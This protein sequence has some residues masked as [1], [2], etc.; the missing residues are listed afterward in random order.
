[1]AEAEF[2]AHRIGRFES[3]AR[4]IAGEKIRV[5]PHPRDGI[6]AVKFEHAQRPARADAVA[7]EKD[8]DIPHHAL[9][10]PRRFDLLAPSV[11]DAVDFLQA[12]G[13]CFDDVENFLAEFRDHFFGVNRTDSLDQSAAEV[14]LDPLEGGGRLTADVRR[15]QLHSVVTIAFPAPLGRD[16]F[17]G[18]DGRHRADHRHQ[19]APAF[20]FHLQNSEPG[21]LVVEGDALDQTRQSVGRG[22]FARV[23]G[24]HDGTKRAAPHRLACA[25][26]LPHIYPQMFR[27]TRQE[28]RL[29]AFILAAFLAGLGIKHWKETRET[30]AAAA[31]MA[32]AP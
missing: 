7:V 3:D 6:V 32:H 8:H 2:F 19:I 15:A 26:V 13:S 20:H 27:L 14:F 30:E 10:G 11:T 21:V 12:R 25:R 22:L 31:K 18:R 28:R 4:H 24:G 17:A 9:L 1:M 16:P 23:H 5:G 29:V